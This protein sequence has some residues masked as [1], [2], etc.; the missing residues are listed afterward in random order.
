MVYFQFDD[1]T[2][3]HHRH[4][5]A[6]LSIKVLPADTII[7]TTISAAVACPGGDNDAGSSRCAIAGSSDRHSTRADR[8]TLSESL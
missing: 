5:S 7:V 8:N 1:R 3:Q 4:E 6:L 2:I